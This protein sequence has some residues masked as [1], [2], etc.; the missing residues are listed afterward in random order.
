MIDIKSDS[1]KVQKGDTFI[2]IRNVARDGHDYIESA[3]KNGATKI[4][5]EEG[6]FPVETIHVPDTRKYLEDYLYDNYYPKIKDLKLIGITGTSGKTTTAYLTYQMLNKLGLKTAYIGTIGFYYGNVKKTLNNTTPDV[7]L[8][9]E[10][11]LEAKENGC[12]CVVMEVSSHALAL[13][14]IHGLEFDEV[15]FTNISQDHLDYHKTIENYVEAK[16]ILF[17]KTRNE[18]YAIINCDDKYY[19]RFVIEGNKNILLGESN[20]DVKIED[21]TLSHLYTKFKFSYEAKTYEIK[22]NMV[23]K[24]NIYNYLT[25]LM[26]TSKAGFDIDKI[27]EITDE[28]TPPDGRMEMIVNKSNSIFIDYAHKPDA[29]EK[30][31]EMAKAIK[32]GKIITII[33]CGGDRDRTKRPIM[34]EIAVRLSDHVIFTDDNPRTEDPKQIMDDI[35]KDLKSN[36]FE[37]I[38]DRAEA[39]KKGVSMLEENDI[40]LI[41]GKGHETY[42]IIGTEKIH[43]SD[44]EEVLKAIKEKK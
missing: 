26:L 33:G 9:Y 36:N 15:A 14:R 3:I 32:K 21:Y 22:I 12:K 19:D 41:L 7:D 38:F 18:K 10:M 29:E 39:I 42:Q 2:A 44:K 5:C 40:L 4:I 11:L 6:E 37:I 35:V 1:R 17:T 20:A 24:F 16:R 30:V 43:F 34:G 8:L 25:A 31:L 13:D 23:C 27:L 28:I